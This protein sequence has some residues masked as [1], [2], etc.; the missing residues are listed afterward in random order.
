MSERMTPIPF[1]KLM[2]WLLSEHDSHGSVFGVATPYVKKDVSK[3]L[4]LFG[5]K[6]ETPFGPAAGPNTQLSQNIIAAYYGGARFFELKTVQKMDGEELAA[7]IARPC[8]LASDEG[9]NCEWSTEL[10]VPQ[11]FDEYVKGWFALRFMAHAWGLGAPDGFMFNISVGYDLAGI[12]TPKMQKF[13]DGMMD[14]SV[15]PIF[16]ECVDTLCSLFP[17]DAGFYRAT[18]GRIVSGVTVSTLHGCPPGEIEAIASYLITEKHLNT[19]VKCNPTILGYEWA[20]KRMDDMGYDYVAFDDHHFKEDLQWEDAVPMFRRLMQLAA[21]HGLEFGLKLSNTF[22]VDVKAGELPSQEMYMSGRAEFPLTIEMARRFSL[23]FQGKLRLSYSGGADF[24][25]IEQ[26]FDAGIWPITMATTILKPGGY[27]R[28]AQLGELFDQKE[29]RPFD[30]VDFL[31][32]GR[33]SDSV[34]HNSHYRKSIKPLPSRKL[35]EKVPLVDCFTAPC[36]GGCPIGQDIPEYIELCGKGDYVGALKVITAKNALPFIT[37]TICA[38]HCMDKCTRNFYE[39]SVQI[40]AEKLKAAEGGYEAL[41]AG[42]AAPAKKAGPKCAVIGGGPAGIAAGYFLARAGIPVTVFEKQAQLGG[43]VRHVIPEFR[44][45]HAAIDK[46]IALAK[47]VGAEFVCVAR[48]FFVALA[49]R[50]REALLVF[51]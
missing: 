11:A 44:I 23:E 28:L 22:P 6:L 27:G 16:K 1:P 7:C 31:A 18:P 26:L 4:S 14:A 43:I 36:K 37:G 8:I 38:H 48:L 49:S 30:G 3:V 25:N 10:T 35:A 47:A 9:Y 50:R 17:E 32:V 39:E 24:F 45:S 51:R 34:Y 21:D 42:L 40:R 12:Q 13:I 2:N 20:R 46:D 41:M 5:E 29:F 15:T 19:F 33:L